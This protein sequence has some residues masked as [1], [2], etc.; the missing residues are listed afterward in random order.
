MAGAL[1]AIHWEETPSR[2]CRTLFSNR[3]ATKALHLAGCLVFVQDI[4]KDEDRAKDTGRKIRTLDDAMAEGMEEKT[5]AAARRQKVWW[6]ME[7]CGSHLWAARPCLLQL[8]S[9]SLLF[10]PVSNVGHGRA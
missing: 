8:P 4:L 6:T 9:A 3:G 5:G 7:G 10:G 1:E 2:V